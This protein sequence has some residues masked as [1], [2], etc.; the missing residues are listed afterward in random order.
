MRLSNLAA[1]KRLGFMT[2]PE[3]SS[4][5]NHTIGICRFLKA[6]NRDLPLQE[7]DLVAFVGYPY[8]SLVTGDRPRLRPASL[9]HYLSDIRLTHSALRNGKL[10]ATRDY[11]CLQSV[12]AGYAKAADMPIPPSTI[13]VAIPAHVLS[14]I[15]GWAARFRYLGRTCTMSLWW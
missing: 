15:L 14:F 8:A 2:G 10:P 1:T 5:V 11:L 4:L 12:Y 13:G 7:K 9:P 6:K 3:P